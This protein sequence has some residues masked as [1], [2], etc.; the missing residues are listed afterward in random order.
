[1]SNGRDG[2]SP[3]QSNY[4]WQTRVLRRRRDTRR[5]THNV[6]L[7]RGRLSLSPSLSRYA[8]SA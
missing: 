5:G 1:M 8:V 4:K 3:V 2:L 7:G 6:F